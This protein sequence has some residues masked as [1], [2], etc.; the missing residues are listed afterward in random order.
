MI[1]QESFL[2]KLRTSFDLNIYEVKIWTA[3]LSRG[4]ASA[5]ELADISGVPRSRSYDV[6]ETLEKKGFVL[7]KLG[8]PIKY[9]AVKPEEVIKRV[10]R[11][12]EDRAKEHVTDLEKI[13]ETPIY[14]EMELLYKQGIEKVDATD[15][16]GLL[17]GRKNIHDHLKTLVANAEKSL[18]IVTTQN[19]FIRKTDSLKSA[20]KRAKERG[21]KI[22]IAAPVDSNMVAEEIKKLAEVRKITGQKA[23]FVIADGKSVLFMLA[24]DEEVHEAYDLGVWVST[25]FFANALEQLFDM[26]WQNLKPIQ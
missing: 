9:L 24:N 8:K 10:R 2:K 16:S 7:M 6:L 23:R 20:L 25:P 4:V 14:K 22:R 26:S 21:V 5:G 18:T 11:T 3:L 19:G 13:H 15:M 17:K 1:V 12:V